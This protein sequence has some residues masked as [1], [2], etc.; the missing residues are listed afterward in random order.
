[1]ADNAVL[2]SPERAELLRRHVEPYALSM[3]VGSLH[4]VSARISALIPDNE[5]IASELGDATWSQ[6]HPTEEDGTDTG[7]PEAPDVTRAEALGLILAGELYLELAA[8]SEGLASEGRR[9]VALGRSHLRSSLDLDRE[10][11]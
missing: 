4:M 10:V 6:L 8:S 3:F 2:E 9:L 5:D 11:E 7:T 1:M